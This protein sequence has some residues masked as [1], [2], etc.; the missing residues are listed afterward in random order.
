MADWYRRHDVSGESMAT[1]RESVDTDRAGRAEAIYIIDAE[2][3]TVE[4]DPGRGS[5]EPGLIATASAPV[6]GMDTLRATSAPPPRPRE[7]GGPLFWATGVVIAVAAFWTSGGH[8]LVRSASVFSESGTVRGLAITGVTSRIDASGDR[9][10][11]LV[12][13]AAKNDGAATEALPPLDIAVTGNDGR[14]TNY[15]LGTSGRAI[16]P[17]ERFAFSSRLDVHKNGVSTVTVTFGQ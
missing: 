15:R 3:E 14:I 10:V 1:P 13:G 11:L 6:S 17:G 2:Y 8:A 5:R 4:A 9:P 16:A 12:D 7:R